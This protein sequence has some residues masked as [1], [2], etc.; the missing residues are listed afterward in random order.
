MGEQAEKAFRD[1]IPLFQALSDPYRQDIVLM[2]S[3]ADS[4]TVNELTERLPLSRP[5]V[6]HH[7]KILRE[8]GIL[9]M[10]QHGTQ[11]NYSLALEGALETLK[12]LIITVEDRC[13]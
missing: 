5:A 4:M 11:R 7:L 12:H 9:K 13:Y 6:S 1:C 3:D 10:E 2:L 8:Q